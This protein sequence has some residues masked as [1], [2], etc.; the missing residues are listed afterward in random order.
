MTALVKT[1]REFF[2]DLASN[3]LNIALFAPKNANIDAE[4]VQLFQEH[5]L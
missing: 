4:N 5:F 3:V 1:L 2:S